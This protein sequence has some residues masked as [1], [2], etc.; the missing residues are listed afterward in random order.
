MYMSA[1]VKYL[2]NISEIYYNSLI[3]EFISIGTCTFF[4]CNFMLLHFYSD[5]SVSEKVGHWGWPHLIEIKLPGENWWKNSL[6]KYVL[7][8][9][10]GNLQFHFSEQ[11]FSQLFLLD[12][13]MY[14]IHGSAMDLFLLS[15]S[16]ICV[17]LCKMLDHHKDQ[18][19][20]SCTGKNDWYQFF[21]SCFTPPFFLFRSHFNFIPCRSDD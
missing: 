12:L 6:L 13:F 15:L 21:H 17:L 9:Q 5:S 10:W 8:I 1:E 11:I 2:W 4:L 7:F 14:L 3:E 18:K 16:A 19:M 20:I